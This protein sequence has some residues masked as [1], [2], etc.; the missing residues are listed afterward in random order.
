MGTQKL[1]DITEKLKEF[2]IV[3]YQGPDALKLRLQEIG[4][5]L[6]CKIQ[7]VSSTPL[8][9]PRIF[10]LNTTAVALRREESDCL[11]VSV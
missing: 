5:H 11:L 10:Q 3:G 4:F 6:G 1:S 2:E 9:G 7:L 8:K